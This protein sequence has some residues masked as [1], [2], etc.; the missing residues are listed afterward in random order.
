MFSI[1]CLNFY[2]T[3]T[4]NN[5]KGFALHYCKLQKI[6]LTLK[7]QVIINKTLQNFLG[8]GFFFCFFVFLHKEKMFPLALH[9][10]SLNLV[11]CFSLTV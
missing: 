3:F 1:L 6:L 10:L 8:S 11:L 7:I 4:V 9:F 5:A 2:L